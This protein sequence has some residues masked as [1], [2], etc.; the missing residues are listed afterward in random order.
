MSEGTAKL[1]GFACV[2]LLIGY[3]V[4]ENADAVRYYLWSAALFVA[5]GVAIV[6]SIVA[7]RRYVRSE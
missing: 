5:L 1:G 3:A 2:A 7:L 4:Y 6:A